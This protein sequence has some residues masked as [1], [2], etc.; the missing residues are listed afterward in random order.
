M[1]HKEKPVLFIP[2]GHH[3]VSDIC[4]FEDQPTSDVQTLMIIH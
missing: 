4:L 3:P 1:A 2:P